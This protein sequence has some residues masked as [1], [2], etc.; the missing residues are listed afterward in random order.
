MR[1]R[2]ESPVAASRAEA[3]ALERAWESRVQA[4][5]APWGP[6]RKDSACRAAAAFEASAAAPAEVA[7]PGAAVAAESA[8]APC[9]PGPAPAEPE[10]AA[11]LQGKHC[12]IEWL[13][14]AEQ[15]PGG[16]ACETSSKKGSFPLCDYHH[17]TSSSKI[18]FHQGDH[19]ERRAEGF[20]LA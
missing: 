13:N 9:F 7:G 2:A 20:I 3:S 15:L 6:S 18:R 5:Q 4:A 8:V 17:E 16:Q 12:W 19:L 14:R 11:P 10:T 1:Q